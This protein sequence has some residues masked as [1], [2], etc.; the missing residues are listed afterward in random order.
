MK[1]VVEDTDSFGSTFGC[2]EFN[3]RPAREHRP[4]AGWMLD[5]KARGVPNLRLRMIL[6]ENRK[7]LKCFEALS[8]KGLKLFSSIKSMVRANYPELYR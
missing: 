3:K 8:R 4:C 1:L 7:A 5:Q 2:H 6:M